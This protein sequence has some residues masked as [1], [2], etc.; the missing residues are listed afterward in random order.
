MAHEYRATIA[1]SRGDAKFTDN[2]YSRAHTWAFDGGVEVPASSAPSSVRLPY[3]V[4]EAVDPEEALVAAASSCHMLTFLFLAANAG[5]VVDSY[6][7]DALGVMTKN[8]RGK[9]Y[10]SKITLR[11]TLSCSGRQPSGEELT[12]LHHRAH[13]ECYIANS[14]LSEIVVEPGA[15]AAV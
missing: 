8:E 12:D 14:I 5:L 9:L 1:W 7:D 2:R 3:S 4:A 6:R 13:E 11:P 10:I 15:T